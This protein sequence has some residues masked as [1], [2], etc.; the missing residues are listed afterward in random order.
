MLI[1]EPLQLEFIQNSVLILKIK[2]EVK[3][4]VRSLKVPCKITHFIGIQDK[5]LQVTL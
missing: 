4:R 3:F 5:K 2:I 1:Q